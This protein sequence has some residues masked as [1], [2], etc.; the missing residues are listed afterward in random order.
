M[1]EEEEVEPKIEESSDGPENHYTPEN[2]LLIEPLA[3][4][5]QQEDQGEREVLF[6]IYRTFTDILEFNH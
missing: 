1:E 6:L 5:A 2:L 3:R 4:E